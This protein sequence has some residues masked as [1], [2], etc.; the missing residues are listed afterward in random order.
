M[1]QKTSSSTEAKV[2]TAYLDEPTPNI[3][4]HTVV[5]GNVHNIHKRAYIRHQDPETAAKCNSAIIRF[6][7]YTCA[8]L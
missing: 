3:T 6:M 5:D 7:I 8:L 2:P 1:E 4:I